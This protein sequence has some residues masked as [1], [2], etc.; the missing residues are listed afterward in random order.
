MLVPQT[1]IGPDPAVLRAFAAAAEA[2][3]FAY[4][5][6]Y[7]HV[8]GVDGSAHPNWAG[9]YG[10]ADQFHEAL[11][12]LGW[13]AG[14]CSLGLATGVL[15]LPQR[16]T[17]LVAKQA[18]EVDVLSGG[19]LRLGVG[20][21]W[22]S[23]EFEGLGTSFADRARRYE[24]QIAVLRLLWTE[25]VV[26]FD[27]RFHQLSS[28]GLLPR[29]V[30]RPVPLWMGGGATPAS[31]QRI[32]R[33]ADGWMALALPGRGLEPMWDEVQA[34]AADAG[35]PD[36]A[37]GLE[38]TAQPGASLERL[39]RQVARWEEAGATHVTVSGLGAARRPLEHL[40]FV[41]DAGRL[42]FG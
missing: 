12:C 28:V 32:G 42:L 26:R 25:D 8:L 21:G 11:V 33:L 36:G 41:A 3:G 16:Q 6:L 35:R 30:Q 39:P 7:D 15:V 17:A 18:A 24:E 27:G 38:G 9:P 4:L 34:A 1:E 23:V 29:P 10:I 13:L 19:R 22:N 31:R 37:V 20:I 14:Q 5:S 2:A 40:A